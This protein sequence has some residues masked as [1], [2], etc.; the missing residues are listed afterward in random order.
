[1]VTDASYE[2]RAW[3]CSRCERWES[4]QHP[5]CFE[6]CIRDVHRPSSVRLPTACPECGEVRRARGA[7]LCGPCRRE[8]RRVQE[9]AYWATQPATARQQKA[10]SLVTANAAGHA[11]SRR[12][13]FNEHYFDA[14]DT[15]EKAYWL[16]FVAGDGTVHNDTLIISLAAKDAMHLVHLAQTLGDA[17]LTKAAINSINGKRYPQE[18]LTAT[19][20]I[21]VR[22][23]ASHGV[24]SRKSATLLPWPG[25]ADLMRHYWRGLIDA[26]GSVDAGPRSS[27]SL[28][29]TLPVVSAF[30][31]WAKSVRP[32][33]SAEPHHHSSIWRFRLSG[34]YNCRALADALYSDATIALARKAATA[35]MII[36][37]KPGPHA[38][39]PAY[40]RR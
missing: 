16:G 20:R 1:M 24:H 40:C 11:P 17:S 34:G 7:N 9:T 4:S 15:A 12:H 2:W 33:I 19:S 14:V 29:G 31:A 39:T 10:R 25:P 3:Y 13:F 28:V 6:S 18:R 30:G 32:E 23:L 22:A 5:E 8:A 26:D 38:G 35:A 21:L 37:S 27:I 36:A